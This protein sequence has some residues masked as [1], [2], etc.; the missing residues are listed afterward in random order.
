M[1]YGAAIGL[2]A[3]AMVAT[4]A[5]NVLVGGTLGYVGFVAAVALSAWFGGL[6]AGLLATVV[7]GVLHATIFAVT[8]GVPWIASPV[9]LL[10]LG[11]FC[12]DG[13]LI[14]AGASA[15]R[16]LWVGER[17]ARS[18]MTVLYAAERKA[19]EASERSL[20]ALT[21]LA[22]ASQV[23]STTSD[24]ATALDEVAGMATSDLADW[25][26]I[27]ITRQDRSFLAVRHA[28]AAGTAHLRELA[29]VAPDRLVDLFIASP[30]DPAGDV[31]APRDSDSADRVEAPAA[32]G[33]IE[34][35]GVAALVVVPIEASARPIGGIV[36]GSA[37]AD[38]FD[39]RTR[40]VARDLAG[41][42]GVAV[43]RT[44]LH[45]SVRRFE[46][47]VDASVDAVFMFEPASLRVTYLNGTAAAWVGAEPSSLLGTSIL[48]V[49]PVESQAGF[50]V[51]LEPLLTGRERTLTYAGAIIRRD[52]RET[53]IE[54]VLQGVDLPGGTLILVLTA[55]DISE[56]IEVQAQLARNARDE[57]NRAA[58]LAAILR[59]MREGVLVVDAAGR[60]LMASGAAEEILG[61]APPDLEALARR[62]QVGVEEL[63]VPGDSSGPRTIALPGERW[64]EVSAYP[65]EH[66]GTEP[67]G[68]P[69]STVIVLRDI[70]AARALS[71]A[72]EAFLGVLSHELRTPVTSI[73]GY[74]KVLQRPSRADDAADLLHDIEAESERLFR[75]V[76]DLLVL[77]HLQAGVTVDGEPL[78]LQHLVGPILA[79]EAQ[80]WPHVEFEAELSATLPAVLGERTYVEQVVRNLLSNAAKYSATPSVVTISAVARSA[81]VELRVLDRGMGILPDEADRLFGLFYRS[82]S[83]SRVAGGAGIGLFVCRG[84][85]HAMGGRIWAAPRPDGGSEFGFS[86]PICEVE[87]GGE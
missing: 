41:R 11:L 36:F 51:R 24:L 75:I 29:A 85:V 52:G 47:T 76:E 21:F 39:E 87:A 9:E 86:L 2:T 68:V 71:Q 7:S 59:A 83:T 57:R 4:I 13:L 54:A 34:A 35:L 67:R 40:A 50:R 3:L 20:G 44:A 8:P 84:L 66:L 28:T 43:E 65:A 5:A 32:R 69:D 61:S 64:L 25:C 81:E 72:R 30:P 70:T 48:D 22:A 6:G 27:E 38:R 42:I 56:R 73:Y 58:E 80:R 49:Q 33:L 74:A 62:L 63:P 46:A 31:V 1:R 19:R 26:A 82:P 14:S 55:R 23:L 78:L 18:Q 17:R 53:P 15:L 60:I 45:E 16:R 37:A 79:A 12:V 10:R 77:S